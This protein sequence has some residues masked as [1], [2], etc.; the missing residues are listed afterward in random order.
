MLGKGLIGKA[1]SL[2]TIISRKHPGINVPKMEQAGIDA[3]AL[4]VSAELR[5][6]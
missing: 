3:V 1:A 4:I 5:V 6:F 2:K